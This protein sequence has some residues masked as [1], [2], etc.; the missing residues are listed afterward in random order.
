[1]IPTIL[2]DSQLHYASSYKTESMHLSNVFGPRNLSRY[3]KVMILNKV[4]LLFK[5]RYVMSS[6]Q[7]ILHCWLFQGLCTNV[8]WT[9]FSQGKATKEPNKALITRLQ[10]TDN[11]LNLRFFVDFPVGNNFLLGI[12][13]AGFWSI[14]YFL[15]FLSNKWE[16]SS[17]QFA[18]VRKKSEN[19]R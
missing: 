1:M 19:R 11:K 16:L 3:P 14:V 9:Y 17:T 13:R 12:L 7:K 10:G 18:V 4:V 2:P 5:I 6:Y 15:G 8:K